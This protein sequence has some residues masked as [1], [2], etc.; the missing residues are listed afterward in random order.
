MHSIKEPLWSSAPTPV[1]KKQLP[2]ADPSW[3]PVSVLLREGLL[4]TGALQDASDQGKPK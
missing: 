3:G 2:G 1:A 4:L